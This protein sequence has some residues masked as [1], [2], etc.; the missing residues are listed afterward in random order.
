MQNVTSNKTMTNQRPAFEKGKQKEKVGLIFESD[1]CWVH[2]SV[3][4]TPRFCKRIL[5]QLIVQY[6]HAFCDVWN[7]FFSIIKTFIDHYCVLIEVDEIEGKKI[8][9]LLNTLVTAFL[10]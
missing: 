5:R 2:G 6:T 4:Y 7:T 3:K 1:Y 10:L 9:R 8:H